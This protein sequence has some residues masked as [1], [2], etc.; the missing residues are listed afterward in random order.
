VRS[1]RRCLVLFLDPGNPA[2]ALVTGIYGDGSQPLR[3]EVTHN[4]NQSIPNNIWTAVTFNSERFDN[5]GWHDPAVNGSR[6][7]VPVAGYYLAYGYVQ[8]AQNSAGER[9][10]GLLK[11]GLTSGTWLA[12]QLISTSVSFRA[13]GSI[14][15]PHYFN[16]GDYVELMA[17]QSSGA[18]LNLDVAEGAPAFGMVQLW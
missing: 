17:Y 14:S 10:L 2:D 4:A 9:F 3:V 12:Q 18:A 7:T 6:L 5:A 11:N 1:G 16:A 15:W 8:F 13:R